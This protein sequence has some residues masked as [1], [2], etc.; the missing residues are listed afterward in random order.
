M[1]TA[2]PRN[3]ASVEGLRKR[4]LFCAADGKGSC[5][6]LKRGANVVAVLQTTFVSLFHQ[7]CIQPTLLFNSCL[8]FPTPQ[9]KYSA[10]VWLSHSFQQGG[11]SP[12]HH[13]DK[14]ACWCTPNTFIPAGWLVAL[15]SYIAVF[16]FQTCL[17]CGHGWEVCD[18]I[19]DFF[20]T[21]NLK[22]YWRHGV[23]IPK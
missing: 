22:Q 18:Y 20:P 8:C 14:A 12:W 21:S 11:L 23:T 2:T 10:F 1:I 3:H 13:W 17:V 19:S 4:S 6:S 15:C 16:F 5:R 7:S 9:H